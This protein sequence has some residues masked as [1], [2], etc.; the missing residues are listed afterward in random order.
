MSLTVVGAA[1]I[2]DRGQVLAAQ[3]AEPDRLAGGWEFPGGKVEPGE[4]DEAALVRECREELG[5]EVEVGERLGPDIPLAL[6]RGVL[7]VWL[8]RALGEPAALE[9]AALRWLD[10]DS[11]D[12]VPWLPADAPLIEELR[13]RL[14]AV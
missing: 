5:V 12:D 7:R 3:R 11:L 14:Q 1:I 2:N 13:T 6:G 9:H 10:A 8:A 4:R